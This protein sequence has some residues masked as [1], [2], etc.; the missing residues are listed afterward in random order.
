MRYFRFQRDAKPLNCGSNLMIFCLFSADPE[1]SANI[2]LSGDELVLSGSGPTI[3]VSAPNAMSPN[4]T[5]SKTVVIVNNYSNNTIINVSD[6]DD[7]DD[8]GD[9]GDEDEGSGEDTI[10]IEL[11]TSGNATASANGSITVNSKD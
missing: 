10:N 5:T 3:E 8:D 1:L 4:P 6:G 11:S 7:G 2:Q 9:D